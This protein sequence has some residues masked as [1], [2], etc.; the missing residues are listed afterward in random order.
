[1]T[2]SGRRN[3]VEVIRIDV[4]IIQDSSSPASALLEASDVTATLTNTLK[5]ANCDA[6]A[7]LAPKAFGTLR[8]IDP[9]TISIVLQILSSS[10]TAGAVAG[11]F[12]VL[13]QKLRNHRSKSLEVK[14]G[15]NSFKVTGSTT[16]AEIDHY[17]ETISSQ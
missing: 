6:T 10:A 3:E 2:V 12:N 1:M 5:T 13:I 9:F 8:S 11:L 16:P 17:V 4:D 15:R 14:I 7:T